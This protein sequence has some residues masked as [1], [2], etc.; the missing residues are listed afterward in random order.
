VGLKCITTPGVLFFILG[1]SK[2]LFVYV[3]F[4]H[5]DLGIER[6]LND[7]MANQSFAD[8]PPWFN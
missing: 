8:G 6:L 3:D 1:C 2:H 4:R 7:C 5:S